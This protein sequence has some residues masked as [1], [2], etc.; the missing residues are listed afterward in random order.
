MKNK[1]NIFIGSM[2]L[3][4]I[5]TFFILCTYNFMRVRPVV[6]KLSK[7]NTENLS[8]FE[9]ELEGGS[10]YK[11]GHAIVSGYLVDR[12]ETYSVYD[13]AGNSYD[14]EGIYNYNIVG[15]KTEDKVILFKT[16]AKERADIN[17]KINDNID[18]RYCGFTAYIPKNIVEK[19]KDCELVIATKRYEDKLVLISSNRKLGELLKDE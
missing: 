16:K 17:E 11:D 2:L 10:V 6:K 5:G 14:E 1:K 12:K 9:Y 7:F 18:Y 15:I 13:Y 3:I 19:Y 4:F 8:G